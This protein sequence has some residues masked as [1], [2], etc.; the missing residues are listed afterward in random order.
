MT[1]IKYRFIRRYTSKVPL[2]GISHHFFG[3]SIFREVGYVFGGYVY[4][5]EKMVDFVYRSTP[6]VVVSES[7][8]HE[9]IE[10]G[11]AS[12]NISIVS[13]CID[14]KRFPMKTEV[15]DSHPVVAYFGRLKKYKSVDHLLQAFAIVVKN[16]PDARLHIMGTGNLN[17]T[18]NNWRN[19]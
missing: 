17:P 19:F 11:F 14:Q 2:L 16:I 1:L 12:K 9:F 13:N 7:T 8:L 3:K 18:W 6:M 4:M 5:A 15:K 10:R